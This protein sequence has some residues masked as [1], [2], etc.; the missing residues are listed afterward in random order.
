MGT[1]FVLNTNTGLD[2]S[3]DDIMDKHDAVFLSLGT[4][5]SMKSGM[6]GESSRGVHRALD[7]PDK[8]HR[9]RE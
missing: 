7:Y 3:F 6:P 4:Y 8:H 5:T 2:I 9:Y 1:E